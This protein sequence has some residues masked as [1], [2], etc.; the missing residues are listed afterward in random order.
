MLTGFFVEAGNLPDSFPWPI[1]P[2]ASQR[3]ED[4]PKAALSLNAAAG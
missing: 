1:E 3:G 4:H 2:A